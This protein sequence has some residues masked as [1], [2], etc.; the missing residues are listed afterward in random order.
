[1]SEQI[2]IDL[3]K[4][5]CLE[6]FGDLATQHALKECIVCGATYF[7]PFKVKFK[8]HELFIA[9]EGIH[10]G[11]GLLTA[12]GENNVATQFTIAQA[13]LY[14]EGL[15][16]VKERDK[17]R[18]SGYDRLLAQDIAFI[19]QNQEFFLGGGFRNVQSE[20]EKQN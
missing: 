10:W 16:R 5:R 17:K 15:D 12:F 9:F 8:N 19:T 13:M 3:F 2:H 20:L 7:N 14:L 1:M 6:S 18:M 11:F 4:N